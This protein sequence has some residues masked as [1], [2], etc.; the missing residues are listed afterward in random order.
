MQPRAS[1]EMAQEE[2]AWFVKLVILSGHLDSFVTLT[3]DMVEETAKEPGVLAYQRFV[4]ANRNVVHAV[5]RYENSDAALAHLQTFREK[6]AGRFSA[7]VRRQ[8]FTVY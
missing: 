3:A 8:R 1:S 4:T 5:E 2:I 7:M 6:F